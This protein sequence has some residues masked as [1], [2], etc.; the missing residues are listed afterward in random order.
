M[1]DIETLE[2]YYSGRL[3]LKG[4]K[5]APEEIRNPKTRLKQAAR[6]CG[7]YDELKDGVSLLLRIRPDRVRQACPHC[8]EIFDRIPNLVAPPTRTRPK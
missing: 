2:S 8:D 1:G 7:G 3:Y 4:L 6:N 5:A